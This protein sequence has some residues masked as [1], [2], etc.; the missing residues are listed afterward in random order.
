[1]HVNLL[2]LFWAWLCVIL[3]PS[4]SEDS[5]K[6]LLRDAGGDAAEAEHD[7]YNTKMC[8]WCSTVNP[9]R[10]RKCKDCKEDL[11]GIG[12][13]R[14]ELNYA[15]GVHGQRFAKQAQPRHDKCA[16]ADRIH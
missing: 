11:P 15:R 14:F 13:V 8:R 3:G 7:P 10:S 12:T 6:C 2:E 16:R 9:K 1:M 4:D 5:E